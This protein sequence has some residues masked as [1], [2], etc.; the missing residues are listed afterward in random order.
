MLVPQRPPEAH[1]ACFQGA[2]HLALPIPASGSHLATPGYPGL[3]VS[4]SAYTVLASG[5]QPT[6]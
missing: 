5:C 1:P 3:S 4:L 2:R 6:S